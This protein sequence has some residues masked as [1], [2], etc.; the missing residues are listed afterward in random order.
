MVLVAIPAH[1]NQRI[2]FIN[3]RDSLLA[4]SPARIESVPLRN[5]IFPI[6]CKYNSSWNQLSSFWLHKH[7]RFD[8]FRTLPALKL[9][10]PT[11][12][13]YLPVLPQIYST[14]SIFEP[15]PAPSPQ[16][17]QPGI[18]QRRLTRRSAP[19]SR[20]NNSFRLPP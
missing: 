12:D 11:T 9:L 17:I 19:T 14:A 2:L 5:P 6:C 4:P 18:Q 15:L 16:L 10:H 20:W 13:H 7:T 8:R 3:Y 1:H